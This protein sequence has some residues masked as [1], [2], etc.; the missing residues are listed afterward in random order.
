[1]VKILNDSEWILSEDD[2]HNDD[3]YK[4]KYYLSFTRSKTS[5]TG[6]PANLEPHNMVRVIFDGRKLSQRY[7]I[8]PVD[9]F[10]GFKAFATKAWHK[11]PAVFDE[12]K[13]EY[14]KQYNVEAEDRLYSKTK[15][16]KGIEKY[17]V[18]VDVN[19]DDSDP[20]KIEVLRGACKKRNIPFN[21]YNQKHFELGR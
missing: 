1:M 8:V 21:E 12:Y 10:G 9:Y 17:I 15:T 4:G 6:Y 2:Y 18:G 13:D 3:K 16:I 5:K 11:D 7:K 20:E 14:M 19:I